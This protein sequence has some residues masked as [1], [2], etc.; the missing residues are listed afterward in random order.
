MQRKHR[1][2]SEGGIGRE[3][4]IGVMIS[5]AALTLLSVAGGFI[6][7]MQNDPLAAMNVA[8]LIVLLVS[9]AASGYIT[10]KLAREKKMTV[11]LLSVLA[12]CFIML[13]VGMIATGGGITWQVPLNY[14]CYM[15]VSLLT[16]RLGAREKRRRR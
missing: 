15:G 16:A 7:Y 8:S 9:G 2:K 5:L 10:A 6:V 4:F 3:V 14:A 13:A 11:A 12:V 1:S